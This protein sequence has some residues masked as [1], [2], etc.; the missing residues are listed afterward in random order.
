[1]TSF[2]RLTNCLANNVPQQSASTPK[3]GEST[4]SSKVT[5]GLAEFLHATAVFFRRLWIVQTMVKKMRGNQAAKVSSKTFRI[6]Q[7]SLYIDRHILDFQHPVISTRRRDRKACNTAG[8]V[9]DA[10]IL[11]RVMVTTN[12]NI[13]QHPFRSYSRPDEQGGGSSRF[14]L[15]PRYLVYTAIRFVQGYDLYRETMQHRRPNAWESDDP[16]FAA[17]IKIRTSQQEA[18]NLF[19]LLSFCLIYHHGYRLRKDGRLDRREQ[20]S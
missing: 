12:C 14:V 16:E 3:K 10:D 19:L 6:S 11:L 13:A 1:M 9:H 8:Y 4:L 7:A 17:Y 5:F 20:T 18:S 2:A 15:R